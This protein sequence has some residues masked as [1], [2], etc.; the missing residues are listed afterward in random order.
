MNFLEISD[1]E[2]AY[3][4]LQYIAETEELMEMMSE[5]LENHTSASNITPKY[6]SLKE[7]VKSDAHELSHKEYDR[8]AMDGRVKNA[9]FHGVQEAAAF[10][11]QSATNS[12][13]NQ[14]L[15]SSVETAHYKL[16]KYL[17]LEEWKQIARMG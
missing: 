6:K 10:G 2:L 5:V 7:S 3:R 9:F 13:I 17:S 14:Q 4:V 11:F 8:F 12:R 16:T 15:F 1:R